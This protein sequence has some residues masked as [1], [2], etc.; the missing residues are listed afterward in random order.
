MVRD[1]KAWGR[2]TWTDIYE[3]AQSLKTCILLINPCQRAAT[4]E[5][6][7]KNKLGQITW[8]IDVNKVS[9]ATQC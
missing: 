8:L 7:L 9:S 3:W 6:T 1:Q 5:R 4:T 2:A